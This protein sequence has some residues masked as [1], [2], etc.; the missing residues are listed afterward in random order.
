MSIVTEASLLGDLHTLY[1][2]NPDGVLGALQAARLGIT[3]SMDAQDAD[4]DAFWVLVCGILVFW[5]Q[6]GFGMIEAGSV[7]VKNVSNIIF[8]NLLDTCLSSIG[9]WALGF[10]F[11]YGV[12]EGTEGNAF[13][14]TG[15]FFLSQMNDQTQDYIGFYWQLV[16]AATAATIISGSVAER[17]NISVYFIYSF[18]V[19]AFIYPVV[20]HWVWSPEGWLSAFKG[21]GKFF[22]CGDDTCNGMIDYSGSGVVHLVGGTAACVGAIFVGPRDGKFGSDGSVNVIPG[23]S[24]VLRALGG[25]ILWMG[26]YGFNCGSTL[27]IAGGCS[28]LAGKI[29]VNTTLAAC[30]GGLTVC[31]MTKVQMFYDVPA[32]CSGIL[33]GL[34]G[35]TAGCATVEPWGS[36]CIG[37][38]AGFVFMGANWVMENKLKIDDPLCATAIHGCCGTWGVLAVGIFSSTDGISLAYGYENDAFKSGLQLGVQVV[39]VCAIWAWTVTTS[40]LMFFAMSKVMPLRVTLEREKTGLDLIEHGGTGYRMHDVIEQDPKDTGVTV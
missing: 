32:T 22:P 38:I 37:T 15:N 35:V 3:E 39:G 29:A 27:C 31:I 2:A 24:H 4:M 36:I 11:A 13:I 34:V 26:W 8:K 18:V 6:S 14:G 19:S 16:F 28:G 1:I 5:M 25:F 10:G 40:S 17:C 21:D 20:A 12:A 30:C 9:F 23:H 33:A 7:R